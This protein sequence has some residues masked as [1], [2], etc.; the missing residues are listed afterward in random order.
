MFTNHGK[1]LDR[2]SRRKVWTKGQRYFNHFVD[3]IFK[4][5]Y[6]ETNSSSNPGNRISRVKILIT[7]GV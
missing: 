5:L 7:H 4:N 1:P 6:N 3:I 2:V